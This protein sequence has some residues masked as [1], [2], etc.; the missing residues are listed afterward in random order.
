MATTWWVGKD[1]VIVGP[2][3]GAAS[4]GAMR[5]VFAAVG[6]AILIPVGIALWR[7]RRDD[8]A[9][10]PAL[11]PS[12]GNPAP[13]SAVAIECGMVLLLML[14]FSPN[15]SRSHFCIMYLPAFCV[16]RLAV[17]P[18]ASLLLRTLL[19]LAVISSTLSIHIRLPSTM[20]AEQVLLWV[21]VVMFCALFLLLACAVALIKPVQNYQ[22]Q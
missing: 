22:K 11:R 10:D 4:A 15:S 16:A 12:I 5:D 14:L 7:H 1:E 8:R 17:R 21:G 6:L 20:L 19:A 18:G 9:P 2:R 13:P 3:P